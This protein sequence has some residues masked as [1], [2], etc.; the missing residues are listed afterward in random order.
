[1]FLR[2][3][4]IKNYKS[5][6]NVEFCPTNLS[7]LVGP[8]GAGKSNF[9]SAVDF[10]SDVYRDG[11][12]TA[13]ARKGGYENIAYR[14][15]RRSR[16]AI[17]FEVTIELAPFES[18][19][20]LALHSIPESLAD[21][22][23]GVWLTHRFSFKARKP[24]IE[25][26]FAIEH[27]SVDVR[28]K[29][30][31]GSRPEDWHLDAELVRSDRG[32]ISV[33]IPRGRAELREL[34]ADL[35]SQVA[36]IN[37]PR[38]GL[39]P[40]QLFAGIPSLGYL[41]ELTRGVANCRVYHIVPSSA[42]GAGVPTPNPFLSMSGENLPAVVAWLKSHRKREWFDVIETMRDVVPEL[43]DV[44]S[45]YLHTKTLGLFFRENTS[46]TPRKAEDVSDGT[47]HALSLLVALADPRNTALVI[48]EVENAFHPW[49]VQ[50][51]LRRFRFASR[52]KTIVLTTH[53]P[54]VVDTLDPSETWVVF[55]KAGQTRLKNLGSINRKLRSAWERGEFR[56]SD[57]LDSGLLPQAV[58]G[59]DR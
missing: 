15:E 4:S 33:K 11:L 32:R 17:R 46:S 5:L 28:V 38:Q 48:E 23:A 41:N 44:E 55:K 16:S 37:R 30:A 31:P 3:L 9:A 29:R 35:T 54:V 56:L 50:S 1:M 14:A 39:S 57:Y 45:S 26:D 51:L 52:E 40:Q 13:V 59:G 53:S 22:E 19:P 49:V 43:D 24:G 10:L 6:K 36:T 2:R 27:E 21:E 42:R 34:R 25:A 18:L 20:L 8:N 7:V 47:I 58:P 12:E